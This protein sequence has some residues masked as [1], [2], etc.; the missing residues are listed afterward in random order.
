MLSFEIRGTL[1]YSL[2]AQTQISHQCWDGSFIFPGCLR[3]CRE[4][5]G[6]EKKLGR[7]DQTSLQDLCIFTA[8][9]QIAGLLLLSLS[10]S[11]IHVDLHMWGQSWATSAIDAISQ[12]L[13]YLIFEMR[14]TW[15]QILCHLH[16]P[17]QSTKIKIKMSTYWNDI[18]IYYYWN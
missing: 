10:T 14:L 16:I 7:L 15:D 9:P 11:F 13:D 8:L 17:K 18:W 12:E 1:F 4:E 3:E 6:V 2:W 5:S